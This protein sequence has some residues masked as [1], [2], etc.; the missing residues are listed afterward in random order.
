ML[1]LDPQL[2]VPPSPRSKAVE[3]ETRDSSPAQVY[4]IDRAIQGSRRHRS[5]S[6]RR[7]FCPVIALPARL[8]TGLVERRRWLSTK[9]TRAEQNAQQRYQFSSI[10]LLYFSLTRWTPRKL[11]LTEIT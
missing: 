8:E 3:P 7:R 9:E 11:T 4:D 6:P 2:H 1:V 5:L 10:V